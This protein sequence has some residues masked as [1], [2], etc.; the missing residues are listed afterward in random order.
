MPSPFARPSRLLWL[1]VAALS[2][3]AA[4]P[5]DRIAAS[6]L[7]G[8]AVEVFVRRGDPTGA[9]GLREVLPGGEGRYRTLI[10][11]AWA[12]LFTFRGKKVF[13]RKDGEHGLRDELWEI[14]VEN[15]DGRLVFGEPKKSAYRSLQANFVGPE[16]G[17]DSMLDRRPYIARMNAPGAVVLGI[18]SQRHVELPATIEYRRDI[19]GAVQSEQIYEL[20][21]LDDDL[22]PLVSL[23]N[24]RGVPRAYGDGAMVAFDHPSGLPV[25]VFLDAK[26]RAR[27][28]E[29]MG[30][31]P[32]WRMFQD[33]PVAYAIPADAEM[34]RWIPLNAEGTIGVEPL[35][36]S[37]YLPYYGVPSR[38]L[39]LPRAAEG[40]LKEYVLPNGKAYGWVTLD[41]SDETGPL[42]RAME[43]YYHGRDP[44]RPY[45]YDLVGQQLDGTWM[46]YTPVPEAFPPHRPL[47]KVGAPSRNDALV[48]Y[49]PIRQQRISE[50]I[51]KDAIENAARVVAWRQY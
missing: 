3:C 26:G 46:V 33:G 20:D 41:L 16:D 15:R 32:F 30:V 10:E 18:R 49:E 2:A 1:F 11:P 34:T 7:R 42:W 5:T 51:K 29:M 40:W 50:Q 21:L 24:T 37:G 4:A 35:P 28:P 6:E 31:T 48:A 44:S 8:V 39:P 9:K 38:K 17:Y 23:H 27:S 43:Q 25:T 12:N 47:L 36:C 13:A 19:G 14:P 22:E 45:E